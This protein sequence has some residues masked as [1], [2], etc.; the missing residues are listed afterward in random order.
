MGLARSV[1]ILVEKASWMHDNTLITYVNIIKDL[2][3]MTALCLVVSNKRV[4]VGLSNC[5][6]Q[7]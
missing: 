2:Q 3:L 1:S 5:N 7:A 6:N 4:T